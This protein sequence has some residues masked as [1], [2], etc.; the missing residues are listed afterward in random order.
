MI[1]HLV[2][3][4][5]VSS[6]FN[7]SESRLATT[8][9]ATQYDILLQFRY[10]IRGTIRSLL[11]NRLEVRIQSRHEALLA[12]RSYNFQH[13]QPEANELPLA[14]ALGTPR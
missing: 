5:D 11:H 4:I 3:Q 12:T 13:P 8:R 14:A 1:C 9:I 6:V 10:I 2:G 7:Q